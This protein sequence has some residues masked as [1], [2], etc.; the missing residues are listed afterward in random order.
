M[1]KKLLCGAASRLAN[2]WSEI[3]AAFPGFSDTILDDQLVRAI[4]LGDGEKRYL[5]V[6]W[7]SGP[8]DAEE[9]CGKLKERTG[10]DMEHVFLMNVPNH[11]TIP[12]ADEA[13]HF[14]NPRKRFHQIR[15]FSDVQKEAMA[16]YSEYVSNQALDAIDEA[17]ANMRPAKMGH[18]KGESY[19]NTCRN[20]HF[21]VEQPDGTVKTHY[22]TGV[23]PKG[24]V[25]R[26]LF[27]IKFIDAQTEEPIAFFVNYPMANMATI[28]NNMG[29]DGKIAIT[30]DVAGNCCHYMEDKFP[31]SVAIWSC[32]PAGNTNPMMSLQMSYP[33]PMTGAPVRLYAKGAEYG[34]IILKLLSTRHFA[35]A[36]EVER[37]ITH[38]TDRT[39]LGSVIEWSETPGYDE[40]SEIHEGIYKVRLQSLRVGDVMLVS[41]SGGS[42]YCSFAEQMRSVS[43]FRETYFIDARGI[44]FANS[45][46]LLDDWV[47][48]QCEPPEIRINMGPRD[49]PHDNNDPKAERVMKFDS[50]IDDCIVGSEHSQIVPG[51]LADSLMAHTV[52]MGEK[53]L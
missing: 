18:A 10:I 29:K 6:C 35:D 42:M 51:T 36:M 33:D 49:M 30:G 12:C 28:S 43:P 46:Y 52:S 37:S 24:L 13:K 53:L 8:P 9:F 7:D 32:G 23:E 14:V 15:K 27:I 17:L 48:E 22:A 3:T 25:D 16:K 4:A 19:I 2:P 39:A 34:E 20:Q 38:F 11:S 26:T 41:I 40:N 5:I 45:E 1:D 21:N 44:N 50:K 47:F 31:G